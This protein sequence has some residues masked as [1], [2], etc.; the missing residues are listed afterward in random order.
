MKILVI[1]AGSSS[2]KYQLFE[3]PQSV[4][5]A[6]GIVERVGQPD[7]V[8]SHTR[9]DSNIRR[10]VQ[11]GSHQEG[12]AII[13]QE[14]A[15]PQTGA[16]EDIR[17]ISAV[18]HRVVHGG[19]EFTIILPGST[20]ET[21]RDRAEQIRKE[22]P[23]LSAPQENQRLSPLT[24]SLGVAAFPY[25]GKTCE[26]LLHAAFEALTRAKKAGRNRVVVA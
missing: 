4:I 18:G 11:A 6:R 21:A 24:V 23:I 3:M 14:L 17:Q 2:I 22:T 12:I 10:P 5:L 20:L 7:A 15:D 19:E 16:V 8:L 26:A 9:N 1:N 25:H 13:L